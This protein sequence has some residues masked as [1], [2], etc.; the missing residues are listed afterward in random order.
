M[1]VEPMYPTGYAYAAE[2]LAPGNGVRFSTGFDRQGIRRFSTSPNLA[3]NV[4]LKVNGRLLH[5]LM[6][7]ILRLERQASDLHHIPAPELRIAVAKGLEERS[8][9]FVR[10]GWV[11]QRLRDLAAQQCSVPFSQSMNGDTH[12]SLFHLKRFS[13]LNI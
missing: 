5:P 2:R 3:V 1:C 12:R 13:D 8:H 11:E 6:I 10:L 7:N 9:F 4:F